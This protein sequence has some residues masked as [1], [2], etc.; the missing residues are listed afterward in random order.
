MKFT[1]ND[2]EI[3]SLIKCEELKPC[4]VC[5]EPTEYVEY[6][7]EVR[8]CSKECKKKLDDDYEETVNKMMAEDVR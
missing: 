7:Y 1:D 2:L 4:N 3:C 5:G 6:C 8:C